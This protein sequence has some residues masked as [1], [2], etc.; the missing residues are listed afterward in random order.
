MHV[1]SV[2]PELLDISLRHVHFLHPFQQQCGV[3]TGVERVTGS[4]TMAELSNVSLDF[5]APEIVRAL[6]AGK[7]QMK[8]EASQDV[9]ALGMVAY[10]LLTRSRAFPSGMAQ[11]DICDQITG[12][13]MLPWENEATKRKRLLQ[14]KQ[15]KPSVLAC[16][17]RNPAERP[18]AEELHA[19][20]IRTLNLTK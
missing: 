2:F 14:L 18:T 11:Q 17:S 16:L 19:S 10:E 6:E 3:G 12:R 15:L 13:A 20:W 7:T 8:V 4:G 9:W 5:A 1:R